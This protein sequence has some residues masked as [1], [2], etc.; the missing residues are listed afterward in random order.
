MRGRGTCRRLVM[1]LAAWLA[2][3]AGLVSTPRV[4]QASSVSGAGELNGTIT[5]S[6]FPCPY[7]SACTA[8]TT[9]GFRGEL[10]GTDVSGKPYTLVF[11]DPTAV[12][13]LP[14][15]NFTT[16]VL[17][18]TDNCPP[19]TNAP[20]IADSGTADGTFQVT[21]GLLTRGAMVSHGA[22]L[23]GSMHLTRNATD[24]LIGLSAL[25]VLASA[26]TVVATSSSL[27]IGDATFAVGAADLTASCDSINSSSSSATFAGATL[28]FA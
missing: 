11:P 10:A 21:G 2:V 9:G 14:P 7:P 4:G 18:F 19:P 13:P 1:V 27:G 5:L 6:Q 8:T 3:G 17:T 26:N 12:P 25:S 15:P 16:P 24:L 20:A 22:V 23:S 28:S